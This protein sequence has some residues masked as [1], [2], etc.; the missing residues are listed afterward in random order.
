[1]AHAHTSDPLHRR[2]AA[3]SGLADGARNSQ[4]LFPAKG[5]LDPQG[6]PT[7]LPEQ[8]IARQPEVLFQASLVGIPVSKSVRVARDP[9][10]GRTI[11]VDHLDR[12]VGTDELFEELDVYRGPELHEQEAHRGLFRQRKVGPGRVDQTDLATSRWIAEEDPDRV[13]KGLRNLN[14][15]S[16]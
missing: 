5:G 11:H 1:M 9:V 8:R 13:P 7:L 2:P 12:G 4:R 10:A 3:G 15:V 16:N 6:E 14:R